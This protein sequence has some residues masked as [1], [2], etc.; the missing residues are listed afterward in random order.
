[1]KKLI[2]TFA[3]FILAV[4][5]AAAQ[6]HVT[7]RVT[8]AADNKPIASATIKVVGGTLSATTNANGQYSI[9]VPAGISQL[10]CSAPGMKPQTQTIKS[11][12]LNF[13]MQKKSPKN[14]SAPAK[15]ESTTPTN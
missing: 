10:T 15:N 11:A 6:T 8:S 14:E 12:T 13:S 2:A 1:M 5:F 3:F 9:D 4:T 7:G